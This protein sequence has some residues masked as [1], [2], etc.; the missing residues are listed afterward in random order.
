M[1]KFL[2]LSLTCIL[3]L[4]SCSKE[5]TV[6]NI[7]LYGNNPDAFITIWKTDNEGVSEENQI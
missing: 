7:D 2:L 4:N 5:D 6:S 3:F 1:K